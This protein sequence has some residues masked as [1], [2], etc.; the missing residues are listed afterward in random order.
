MS[1]VASPLLLLLALL[2]VGAARR[3]ADGSLLLL[4]ADAGAARRGAA[5]EDED[6][7]APAGVVGVA[8]V[9]N[10]DLLVLMLLLLL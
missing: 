4:L 3:G 8:L 6:A 9:R 1:L 7:S 10:L 5:S 2:G